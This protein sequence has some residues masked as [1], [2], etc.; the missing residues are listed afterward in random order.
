MFV[1]K[2]ALSSVLVPFPLFFILLGIGI[3]FWYR[4]YY[5]RAKKIFLFA[6]VWITLLSYPPF[7]SLLLKPLENTYPKVHFTSVHPHYIH[8]LGNGHTTNPNLPLS[9][10][11][12]LVSLARVNEG[13]TLYKSYPNMKL[14]FSGYG[15]EDPI[16]NARKNAQMAIALGVDPKDIII[17]ESPKDTQDEA[18]AVKKIIGKKPLILVT[19]A[20]HM[21]RASLLFR[22]NGINVTEAPTDFQVKQEELLWQFPSSYGL[23]RSEAAFHEYLGL[24][25]GKV[26]GS[27]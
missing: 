6:L 2:K 17:L 5:S 16:S 21:V 14:I 15:G 4:G 24:L 19:S 10:E 26:K 8:V 25:W 3:Y 12:G 1:I 11:L 7:S 20:S 18:I 13:V 27:L 22:Q 23:R 9:S